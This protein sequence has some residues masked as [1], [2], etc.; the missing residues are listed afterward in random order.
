MKASHRFLVIFLVIFFGIALT[1]D[2]TKYFY[3]TITNPL[4]KYLQ[5]LAFAGVYFLS[6]SRENGNEGN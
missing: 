6:T 1:A 2:I 4:W 5:A 3:S